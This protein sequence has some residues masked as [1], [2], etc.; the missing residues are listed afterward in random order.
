M[1]KKHSFKVTIHDMRG[2]SA[3]DTIE[4]LTRLANQMGFTDITINIIHEEDEVAP[5]P[6]K[7]P[8]VRGTQE[9]KS[10]DEPSMPTDFYTYNEL[11]KLR[12]E[13]AVLKGFLSGLHPKEW[14]RHMK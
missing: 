10:H 14:E 13:F 5:G 4:T 1:N 7:V 2:Y 12:S 8:V 3:Q 11:K 9:R 6:F